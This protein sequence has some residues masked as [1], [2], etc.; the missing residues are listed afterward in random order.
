[1][2][3]Y[4]FIATTDWIFHVGAGTYRVGILQACKERT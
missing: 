2:L 1:M 3:S 4:I